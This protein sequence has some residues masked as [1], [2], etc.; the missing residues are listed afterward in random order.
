M[1]DASADNR[2]NGSAEQAEPVV[3][4]L[5][6]RSRAPVTGGTV[7]KLERQGSYGELVELA[8]DLAEK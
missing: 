2:E 8:K 1:S 4:E 5:P 7:E 6:D 3:I